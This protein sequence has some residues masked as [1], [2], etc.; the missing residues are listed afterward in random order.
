M[1]T[2]E[3]IATCAVLCTRVKKRWIGVNWP[4]LLACVGHLHWW[5]EQY[6]I[7]YGFARRSVR[8]VRNQL[9]LPVPWSAC[10]CWSVSVIF[11]DVEVWVA[12]ELGKPLD[13]PTELPCELL[14][15]EKD[16][17]F[18]QFVPGFRLRTSRAPS[19]IWKCCSSTSSMNMQLSYFVSRQCL[20]LYKTIR[21]ETIESFIVSKQFRLWA[22]TRF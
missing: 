8:V 13:T 18:V 1:A 7:F 21:I 3:V 4:I 20:N 6:L 9:L 19:Y 10:Q 16:D 17:V 5:M 11:V 15:E 22:H 12:Y 14:I 2:Y